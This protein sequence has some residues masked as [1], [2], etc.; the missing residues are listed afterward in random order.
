MYY[1]PPSQSPPSQSVSVSV[2]VS[3]EA[4]GSASSSSPQPKAM[5]IAN[6]LIASNKS[7]FFT[8]FSPFFKII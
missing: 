7:N 2:S 6:M 4:S 8:V 3:V 5:E 1:I